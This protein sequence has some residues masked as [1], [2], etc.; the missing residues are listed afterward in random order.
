MSPAEQDPARRPDPDELLRR[1]QA[2]EAKEQRGRLKIWFGASP[3][4]GKTYAML[5]AARREHAAGRA[6][7]I[8]WV[9]TH[10]R[11]ETA[12]QVADLPRL[13]PRRV[14]YRGRTLEEFDLDTALA[15]RPAW[16]LVDELAHTN[17]PGSRHSKRWQDVEELLQAGIDVDT[18]LNVQHLESLNDVV[19]QITGVRVSE[20]LPDEVFERA[21]EVE[22]VDLPAELLIERLREGKVYRGEQ[23]VRAESGFFRRGNLLALRELALRRVADR[24]G[25]D[26][27]AWRE[28]HGI[29]RTWASS[30]RILVCIGADATAARLVRAGH[31]IATGL[32]AEWIAAHVE[33]PAD[34]LRRD[35]ERENVLDALRLAE[36]LGAQAVSLSSEERAE[37]VLDFARD[38]NV[39]R[40]LVGKPGRRPWWQPWRRSMLD[41]MLRESAE[42]EIVASSGDDEHVE[43]QARARARLR[44]PANAKD[45]GRAVLVVLGSTLV[46]WLLFQ[47]FDRTEVLMAYLLGIVFVA[48]Q[49]GRGPALLASVLSVVAFDF[50]FVP[51][52]LSFAVGDS[53]YLLTFVSMLVVGWVIS[54]LTE[55]VR[56]QAAFARERERRSA[57]LYALVRDL[58]RAESHADVARLAAQHMGAV[59]EARV[60][61]YLTDERGQIA[62][63]TARPGEPIEGEEPGVVR[64]VYDNGRP[65]GRG[66]E[67]LPGSRRHYRPIRAGARVFGV[68]ALPGGLELDEPAALLVVEALC[69]QTAVVLE[70]LQLADDARRA[71]LRARTESLRNSILSSISH[72]LR[73]PLASITGTASMLMQDGESLPPML[74]YDLAATVFEEAERLNHLVGNVL[75]ITRLEAG[76]MRVRKEWVP[77]DEVVGSALRRV[78]R[79]L[80]SRQVELELAPDLPLVPMDEVLIEQVLVNLLE[81][82]IKY[83]DSRAP[84]T[85]RAQADAQHVVVTVADRG[86]GVPEEQRERVFE[87][88]FR[89]DTSGQEGVG[90]GLSICRG[91]LAI[92]GGSIEACERSGGGAEFRFRLPVDGAPQAPPVEPADSAEPAQA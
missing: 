27:L 54:T 18:T 58:G 53:R 91:I 16:I 35:E 4:V 76:A 72:D 8:G 84:I 1:V 9:E 7:L 56:R 33:T 50:C 74:R 92:H 88:F 86:P 21:E 28:E 43:P 17:A 79:R 34:L 77:I 37:A 63:A 45:H 24:V 62:L 59:C 10:E 61:V 67:T 57:A 52:Y 5:E 15:R 31:R 13:P 41:S 51:P 6:A 73:T 32:R 70:R 89:S 78:E 11:A 48:T 22:L 55:R 40:I 29:R 64:W 46:G 12:A 20:T 65:A 38:R 30:E 36:S 19:A 42:I 85:L 66:S 81:N 90:L 80:G 68:A 14:E 69:E 3:G 44:R 82:A 47:R 26:V 71:E 75:D 87:K 23:A 39:T 83:G 60:D 2:A 49:Y 25:A